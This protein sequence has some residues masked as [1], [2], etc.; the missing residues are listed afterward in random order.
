MR[1]RIRRNGVPPKDNGPESTEHVAPKAIDGIKRK[2]RNVSD[3]EIV[4]I[5]KRIVF[6]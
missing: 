1:R 5:V 2:T 3:S 6:E 4:S